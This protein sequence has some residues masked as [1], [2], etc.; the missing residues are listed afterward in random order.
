MDR[1]EIGQYQR[2]D[3]HFLRYPQM[4]RV[5]RHRHRHRDPL[6]SAARVDDH[7][8]LA[9]RHARVGKPYGVTIGDTQTGCLISILVPWIT[10]DA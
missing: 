2:P 6:V 1:D 5:D 3:H 10:G 8:H 4:L 9:A 7:G